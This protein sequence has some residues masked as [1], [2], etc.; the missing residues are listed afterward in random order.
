MPV[1]RLEIAT[2]STFSSLVTSAEG[3]TSNYYL[4]QD[5]P[6]L[7]PGM[8]YW[9][10][11]DSLPNGKSGRSES[12]RVFSISCCTVRGD[13]DASGSIDV[14]DLT[15][16]VDYLFQSG[17]LPSCSEEADMDADGGVNVSDLTYIVDYLFRGGPPPIDC[18]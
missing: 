16:L 7:E 5:Q 3:L 13:V 18:P 1:C 17:P 15:Y 2:D 11:I 4:I 8:Y 9:R 6:T 14:A 10:V 12:F